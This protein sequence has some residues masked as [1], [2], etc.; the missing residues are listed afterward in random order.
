MFTSTLRPVFLI[1][2]YFLRY[3]PLREFSIFCTACLY[4]NVI[5]NFLRMIAEDDE[6]D[7]ELVFSP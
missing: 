1:R 4:F 3:L 2:L 6:L 5:D 7:D